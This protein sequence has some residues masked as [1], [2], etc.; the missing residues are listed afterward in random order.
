MEKANYK[1]QNTVESTHWWYLCRRNM[2]K[3]YIK[4]MGLNTASLIF[5][6]GTSTGTNLRLLQE[7]GFKHYVGLDLSPEAIR[8]CAQK[9]LGSLTQGDL[10]KIPYCDNSF[11]FILATDVFEH[12]KNDQDALQE[13]FRILKPGS[14]AIFTVPTFQCIWGL[15]DEVSHHRRRYLKHTFI[16][17]VENAGFNI[18]KS[19]YYNFIMFLP[20]WLAR[21]II[22][23]FNLAL[24]SEAEV[25]TVLINELM[26]ITFRFDIFLS[27]YIEPPVGV[28]AFILASKPK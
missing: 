6:G 13:C 5:D 8:L 21:I 14:K 26:K 16:S 23:K 1:L 28:S 7:M 4:N 3:S 24:N 22:R 19:Y 2:L 12:I 9:K 20:I 27:K 18:E 25:N 15:Q 17:A 10:T 11:D